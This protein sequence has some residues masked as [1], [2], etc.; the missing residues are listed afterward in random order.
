MELTQSR[1]SYIADWRQA[2]SQTPLAAPANLLTPQDVQRYWEERKGAYLEAEKGGE[3][4]LSDLELEIKFLLSKT[5]T[6]L[7]SQHEIPAKPR[8]FTH[9]NSICVLADGEFYPMRLNVLGQ[10]VL[11]LMYLLLLQKSLSWRASRRT[12]NSTQL[13]SLAS[14]V[15]DV[16]S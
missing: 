5:V 3:T 7:L 16:E 6:E 10:K 8:Q 1:H 9:I 11:T 14:V 4:Q 15:L 2:L 12:A 13:S